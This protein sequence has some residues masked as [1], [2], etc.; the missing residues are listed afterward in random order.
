MYLIVS[1]KLMYHAYCKG[2]F[3][4]EYGEIVLTLLFYFYGHEMFLYSFVIPFVSFFDM[5]FTLYIY[6]VKLAYF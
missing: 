3:P 1:I 5:S 4:F 6:I 2:L